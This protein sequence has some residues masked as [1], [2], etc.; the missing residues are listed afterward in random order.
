MKI[1]DVMEQIDLSTIDQLR[2][3]LGSRPE[4][5]K[6]KGP[7]KLFI[8]WVEAETLEELQSRLET[9]QVGEFCCSKAQR[10]A[11]F[12]LA[13]L[14]FYG[15]PRYY[16]PFDVYSV[17]DEKTGLR[18]VI[19]SEEIKNHTHSNIWKHLFDD[20]DNV[21][22]SHDEAWVVASEMKF[23][24]IS[25]GCYNKNSSQLLKSPSELSSIIDLI[26]S[27]INN[28]IPIYLLDN[29]VFER[30]TIP[31]YQ[32]MIQVLDTDW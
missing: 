19:N 32:K 1:L 4:A 3:G 9:L 16:F 23:V 17:Y 13:G 31:T 15:K 8:H 20:R 5:F 11:L 30:V 14:M 12:N 27:C 18:R 21:S 22:E 6:Y 10:G 2:N 26:E 29:D 24:G 25:T 28:N 7:S